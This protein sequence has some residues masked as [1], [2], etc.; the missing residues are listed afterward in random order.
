MVSRDLF[1]RLALSYCQGPWTVFEATEV[2]TLEN[3][4]QGQRWVKDMALNVW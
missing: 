3:L 1:V 2:V 4:L